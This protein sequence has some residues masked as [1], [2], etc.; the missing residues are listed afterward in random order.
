M[1]FFD[2]DQ[3]YLRRLQE[4]DP[5]TEEHFVRYF[6]DLLQIKLR[7]RL[8]SKHT[9]EDIR[10]ETFTRVLTA[11]RNQSGIREPEKLGAF[12]NSVCNNVL[13]EHYRASSRDPREGEEPRDLPDKT[14]NLN[15]FLM[16]KQTCAQVRRVLDLLTEK[17]RRLLR[18][19]FLEDQDKDYVCR[20]FGVERDYLRVLLH[21]AK[22]NFKAMYQKEISP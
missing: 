20:E 3:A 17:D 4:R 11:V 14:I 16:S 12:V 7:S 9:I 15:G 22:Q 6:R 2:F 18:A 1:E 21:R 5:Y 10:Q 19:I 13:L 8:S